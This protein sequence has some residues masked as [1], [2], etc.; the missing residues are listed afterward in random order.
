ME[1]PAI[2]AARLH[3]RE[4]A[5]YLE[6]EVKQLREAQDRTCT[7]TQECGYDGEILH[8]TECGKEYYLEF[9]LEEC[10]PNYCQNCGGKLKA[11]LQGE[12]RE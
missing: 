11:A 3:W 10:S 8:K 5:D 6:A 12:G 9:P 7:W 2:I 4:Y 1:R